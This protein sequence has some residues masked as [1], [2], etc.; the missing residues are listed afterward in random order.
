MVDWMR[1]T[2]WTCVVVLILLALALLD[3]LAKAR[4]HWE[5]LRPPVVVKTN[6]P[7]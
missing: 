2:T 7:T 4:E 6:E 1:I 5:D 3:E